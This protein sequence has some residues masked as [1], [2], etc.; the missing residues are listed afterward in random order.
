MA[1][2]G[3]NI[4]LRVKGQSGLDRLNAKVKQLTK[5]VDNIR[6]IDIMNPRNTGGAGGKGSRNELKKYR[7]DMDNLVNTINKSG[8]VFGKT[9]NQQLAAIDALQEYSNSLTIGSK[10]QRAAVAAT[11]RLTRQT[12]LD[13]VSIL[14]NNKARKQNIALSRMIGRRVGG[15][16]GGG[17]PF[18]MGNPKGTGAALSSGLISGAFPLLFGQG[19]LGGAAGFAGGFAGT[20]LGGKM[21]GFAGGLVA[22]AVLQQ[23]TTAKEKLEELGKAVTFFSFDVGAA[24]KA[25]GLAGTPQAEYIKLIEKSQGKQAAFNLVMQDMEQLVGED[26]VKALQDFAEGTRELQSEITRFLTEVA[27]NVAKLFSNEG[28]NVVGLSRRSLLRDAETSDNPEIQAL[29]EKRD[30]TKNRNVRER[31]NQQIIAL[32]QTEKTNKKNLDLEKLREEQYKA[33]TKSVTDKNQFLN[34]SITL[35]GREAEIREKLREFDRKA[36]EFDKEVNKEKRKQFE[37]ALRLQEELER[38]DTLYKGIASTVQSGLVDAIDG[39]IT[40]T[41]TLGEVARSVFG[42]IRRQLIDF[43]ATSFLRA[44]PGIGGFFAN[45]GV[46]KPNKSY[47]V[48]ERGPELFTPGVTGRV[49]PNHEIMG[50]G[51]TSVVVNVDASGSSVEGDEEQG[52]E[53]GRL[54]SVAIQ[55]ELIKEKRPGG[56]LA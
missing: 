33:I 40:G 49:T 37:N 18:P 38:I 6:Q 11:L 47:I 26:G 42:S 2:Y 12:D 34:E 43:A 27:A 3:V 52:R 21:G 35:G 20:K 22:T 44:I 55:S 29:I 15:G 56:L 54:I 5:S 28:G 1:D 51:S 32:M 7:Q 41:M 24:T 8:K 9:R 13:T 50:G 48:G 23:L 30:K 17:N 25:L 46:T 53:L 31:L 19:L 45:G 16:G 14:E 39:A 36:L 4:N 10:K